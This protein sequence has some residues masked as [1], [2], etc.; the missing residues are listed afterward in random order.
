MERIKKIGKKANISI[1]NV[2]IM[3]VLL[4]AL[5]PVI[6]VSISNSTDDY[7]CLN[8]D[9]PVINLTS[10]LCFNQTLNNGASSEAVT[11]V[12]LSATE[13]T[14]MGLIALFLVLSLV[15]MIVKSSGL[16]GKK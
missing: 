2:V 16:T 5:I 10:E 12:G 3:V 13:V 6:V 11:D 4:V 7:R 8:D 14:L 9:F 15:F 1:I